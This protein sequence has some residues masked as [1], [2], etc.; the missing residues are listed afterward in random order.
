MTWMLQKTCP[1]RASQLWNI[2]R[3]FLIPCFVG[4]V[5]RMGLVVSFVWLLLLLACSIFFFKFTFGKKKNWFFKMHELVDMKRMFGSKKSPFCKDPFYFLFSVESLPHPLA[6]TACS[7]FL[8]P[9]SVNCLSHEWFHGKSIH[10]ENTRIFQFEEIS[11]LIK[12]TKMSITLPSGWKQGT[13]GRYFKEHQKSYSQSYLAFSI[14][15]ELYS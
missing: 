8:P 9:F 11:D 13:S 1:E 2:T 5:L 10:L 12:Y 7:S 4:V 3:F 15:F 6:S 14:L